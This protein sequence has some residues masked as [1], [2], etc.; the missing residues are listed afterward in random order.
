MV[1]SE[2]GVDMEAWESCLRH[3]AL[4][5]GAR[6]LEGV[7]E[8]MGSG[9]RTEPVR[10]KCG[11]RMNSVGLR[12]KTIRTIL[13]P[14][15]FARSL[16]VCP[17][18]GTSRFPGDE[19]LGV[20]NTSFSPGAKRM[21]ARAGSRT[22]FA[23]AEEDLRI[24]AG[25]KVNRKDVERIAE[26]VGD[27]IEAWMREKRDEAIKQE[28]EAAPRA[29]GGKVPVMYVSFDG[30]GVPMRRAE[31]LGRRGKGPDGSAKTRE[32]KLGCVFTQTTTDD[33]GKPVRDPDTTTYDGAIESSDEFGWRIYAQA[34]LRGIEHAENV[35]VLTDGARYNKSITNLHF[36]TATHIIDLYHAREHLH[37]LCKM[38]LPEAQLEA[39]Q[40]KWR[41]LLDA[42]EI[43]T[44][45]AQLKKYLPPGGKLRHEAMREINYFL[46]NAELMR[47]AKFRSKKFFVGSGVV[48]AGCRTL[49]GERLKKSGMFWSLEGANA[50][51]ASRCSQFSR[52]WDQFWEDKASA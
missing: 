19:L 35:V 50:I 11:Q 37:D 10:C 34:L 21:M 42:G 44:L 1:R 45:V 33:R 3:A 18:C 48:E 29:H 41:E 2:K 6:V 4:A 8:D 36:P 31:L 13:G 47:Y 30:T 9:R 5:A 20:Q 23:D 39:L 32:V 38:L 12:E 17:G 43:E 52:R 15:R 46:N 16:F 51:I 27:E 22:S 24:Y 25:I 28:D 49:I 40:G 26:S 7:F 14:V